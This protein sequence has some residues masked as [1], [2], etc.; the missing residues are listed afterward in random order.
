MTDG[1]NFEPAEAPDELDGDWRAALEQLR[2]TA[3]AG[4]PAEGQ[5]SRVAAELAALSEWVRLSAT[6]A[7]RGAPVRG[8]GGQ[9]RVR[10]DVRQRAAPVHLFVD[11]AL[12]EA[13]GQPV[14]V[15]IQ[16]SGGVLRILPAPRGE[17]QRVFTRAQTTIRI[18]CRKGE[19]GELETGDYVASVVDGAIVIGGV[20]GE[21]G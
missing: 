7:A 1:D 5:R 19:I 21:V 11:R 6:P 9:V 20:L 12:W 15:Q 3:R 18:D 10:P 2:A 14:Q 13:I 8:Q 4:L 17:G 16:V